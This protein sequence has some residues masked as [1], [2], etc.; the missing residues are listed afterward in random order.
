VRQ[1]YPPLAIAGTSPW[2]QRHGTLAH[3][4]GADSAAELDRGPDGRAMAGAQSALR[5]FSRILSG[6]LAATETALQPI[7]GVDCERAVTFATVL[8]K[9]D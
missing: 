9:G 5:L 3:A 4:A 1:I 6:F 8:Q 7:T 2:G